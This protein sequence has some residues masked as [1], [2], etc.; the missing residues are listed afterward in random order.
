MCVIV[1]RVFT[2]VDDVYGELVNENSEF[3]NIELA[4]VIYFNAIFNNNS[5][6]TQIY[7]NT[8]QGNIEFE[9]WFK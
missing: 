9:P 3:L 6:V 5:Y 7:C 2:K 4:D 8:P 1:W